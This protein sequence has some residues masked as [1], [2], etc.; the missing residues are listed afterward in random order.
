MVRLLFSI[1]LFLLSL[2]T[3]LRAPTNLLWRTAVAVTEFPY[4]FLLACVLVYISCIWAGNYR[5]VS[6]FITSLAFI[7]FS[8]PIVTAYQTS[9]SLVK[10]LNK[11]FPTTSLKDTLNTPFSCFKMF[12]GININAVEYKTI[13]YKKL[14]DGTELTFDYYPSSSK[15]LSPTVIVIH[16]GSWALGDSKQLPDLNSYLANRGLN[17]ASIN[18]RLAPA[19]KNPA[20]IEDTRTA[21]DYITRNYLSLNADTSDFVLLGRSAGG[22]IALL[23]AYTFNDPRIKGVISF[24]APA[25]MVWG[26]QMKTN[27][28]V[29]DVDK[30][31]SDYIGGPYKSIPDK[32]VASSPFEFVTAHSTP[33]LLIHGKI[34]AM[35]SY[36]HTVH[37]EEKLKKNGVKYFILSLPN[38]THG[39]DYNINGPSGQISTYAIER[40]IASVISK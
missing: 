29:L 33:T 15:T 40:F 23:S 14:I 21:I 7:L 9:V 2:L 27:K 37:M 32:Y 8:I 11:N 16:G 6:V 38:A 19:Y 12:T 35:V 24:Y 13:P 17:V 4:L 22:Q 1:F 5:T 36:Y 25:D 31:L 26:A 39:C 28:W 18:Y 20:P 10:E 30:V 3:V 34:D